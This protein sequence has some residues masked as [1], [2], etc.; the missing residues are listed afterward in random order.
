MGGVEPLKALT[1]QKPIIK[2]CKNCGKEFETIGYNTRYCFA[3][4]VDPKEQAQ[5][6]RNKRAATGLNK[7]MSELN[8][9]N[10]KNKTHLTYGQYVALTERKGRK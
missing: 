6:V 10:E 8:A 9:Y 4:R 2:I 7:I 5:R 1:K 3:C